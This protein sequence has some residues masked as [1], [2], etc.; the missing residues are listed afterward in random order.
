MVIR[1]MFIK[2]IGKTKAFKKI[3]KTEE[4]SEP[5][6]LSVEDIEEAEVHI[7]RMVQRRAFKNEIAELEKIQPLD[8]DASRSA[9]KIA[10]RHTK[11][12]SQLWRLD[13]FI[14]K[15]GLI[16]VGGRLRA[17]QADSTYTFPIILPRKAI[18]SKRIVEYYHA[19]VQHCGRTS[20]I[21]E[22]RINGYWIVSISSKV[23]TI[24]H[25]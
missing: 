7:L 17:M 21:N 14:V 8:K 3:R 12:V 18:V 10:K 16:Q 23:R 11:K 6:Q 5:K 2:K 4:L 25:N 19:A 1:N 15:K 20:T 13:P 22:V 24:V 9:K